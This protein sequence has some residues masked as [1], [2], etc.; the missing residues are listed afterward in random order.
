MVP[1]VQKIQRLIQLKPAALPFSAL[2]A[3]IKAGIV[4]P[5]EFRVPLQF[6]LVSTY[7]LILRPAKSAI[8]A[9]LCCLTLTLKW[10]NW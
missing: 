2:Y 4:I 10:Q 9:S 7:P 6:D 5:V 3:K 8:V 1:G